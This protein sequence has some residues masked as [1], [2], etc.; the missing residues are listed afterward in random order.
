MERQRITIDLDQLFPGETLT[1]GN[2]KL[3]IRPLDLQQIAAVTKDFQAIIAELNSQGVTFEQYSTKE[4]M[5][6][7]AVVLINKFPDVLAEVSNIDSADL[8]QLPLSSLVEI[9]QKVV[10]VNMKSKE[11]LLGNFNSLIK[12]LDLPTGENQTP[13]KIQE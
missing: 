12:A 7:I 4:G 5:F 11:D 6:K 3:I 8:F 2:S 1:I 13:Q 10:S 9:L